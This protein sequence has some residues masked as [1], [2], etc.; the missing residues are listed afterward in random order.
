[1]SN[2]HLWKRSGARVMTIFVFH[3]GPH[4]PNIEYFEVYE[5][6][7]R[8]MRVY[9]GICKY[10]KVYE[11]TWRYMRVYRVYESIHGI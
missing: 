11:G 6:I 10:M 9:E 1:M 8:Y 7:W 5:R 3:I 2:S 4:V